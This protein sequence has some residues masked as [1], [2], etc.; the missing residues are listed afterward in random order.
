MTEIDQPG[1]HGRSDFPER[2]PDPGQALHSYEQRSQQQGRGHETNVGD[3]ERMVSVAAGS[4][5][6][7]LGLGRGGLP[8]LLIGAVGGGMIYR[9]ATGHCPAYA[10]MG[11]DTVDESQGGTRE[12]ENRGTHVAQSFLV[13]KPPEELYR[14]W[15]NFENLPRIMTHLEAVRVIDDRRSHWVAK[16]PSI[17]GG[18]VEWDAEVT[19]D[20]PNA[21]IAWRS[22]PG[23][24]VDNSGSVQFT[25][26]PGDRGT[27][28]RVIIDYDPPAGRLGK[29]VAKLFGEAPERQVREGLRNFKRVMELGEVPTLDGQ[30]HGTCTGRGK[31]DAE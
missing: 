23:A 1:T 9:E 21:R 15:R 31:P 2:R 28:V 7:L 19:A 13:N 11:V 14:Y 16:A 5:L 8:G 20:E 25:P 29:W 4:V 12:S 3:N 6:A 30:P 22:L 26:A 18:Q 10:A 17:T 27:A 24:D